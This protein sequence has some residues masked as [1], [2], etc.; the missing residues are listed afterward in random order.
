MKFPRRAMDTRTGENIKKRGCSMDGQ[1]GVHRG[2]V[3]A[4][5]AAVVV[6]LTAV[7]GAG[8]AGSKLKLCGTLKVKGTKYSFRVDGS[9]CAL[10]KKWIP[11]LVVQ[12]GTK[13]PVGANPL[14][15]RG[16]KGWD[17]TAAPDTMSSG[18]PYQFSGDCQKSASKTYVDFSWTQAPA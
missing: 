2:L 1:R 10:A 14:K 3:F 7:G 15:L 11:K 17:C 4:V 16:L 5:L 9:K 18:Y 13:N 6:T 12:K 8:A